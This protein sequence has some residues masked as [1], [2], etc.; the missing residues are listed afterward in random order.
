MATLRIDSNETY[1]TEVTVRESDVHSENVYV[2]IQKFVIGHDVKDC[3]EMFLTPDQLEL[4]GRFFVRQADEIKS[5]QIH[6]SLTN[7]I[8]NN[9]TAG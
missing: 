7:R 3:G 2:N 1:K 5:K 6:R 8:K 9:P 4:L